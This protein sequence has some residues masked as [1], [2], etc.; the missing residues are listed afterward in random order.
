[1]FQKQRRPSLKA[2]DIF[3]HGVGQE[4]FCPAG[5]QLGLGGHSPS[6]LPPARV[7]LSF[8]FC[9]SLLALPGLCSPISGWCSCSGG[10]WQSSGAEYGAAGVGDGGEGTVGVPGQSSLASILPVARGAVTGE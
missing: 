10:Q 4:T 7:E 6:P 2:G 5:W 1:M 8:S 9:F 3:G